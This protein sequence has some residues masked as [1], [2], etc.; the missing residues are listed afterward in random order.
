MIKDNSSSMQV[1][2]NPP[3]NRNE[4]I[5][6][7]K[8]HKTEL[9]IVGISIPTIIAVILGIKNKDAIKALWDSLKTAVEERNMYSPKWFKSTSDSVLHTERER[10]RLAYCSSGNDMSLVT[11]LENLLSRFDKELSDRAWAGQTPRG[12]SYHREHG[13]NLYK[14]D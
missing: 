4:L 12:P 2:K 10:V 6:W 3:E 1:A 5:T 8:A 11:Q 9:I 7:I 13:F 14:P